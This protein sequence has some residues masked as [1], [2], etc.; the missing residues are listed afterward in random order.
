M[1]IYSFSIIYIIT[2]LFNEITGNTIIIPQTTIDKVPLS[3]SSC[4]IIEEGIAINC[5]ANLLDYVDIMKVS[6]HPYLSDIDIICEK[7]NIYKKCSKNIS[8]NCL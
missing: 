8:K 1:I 4:N 6:L 2:F 3:K 5:S 7:L